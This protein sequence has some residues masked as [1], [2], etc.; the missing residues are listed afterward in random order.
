MP[1]YAWLTVVVVGWLLTAIT[2]AFIYSMVATRAKW[3]AYIRLLGE[4]VEAY[5]THPTST[6]QS[7]IAAAF[8]Q[9]SRE[10]T[11]AFTTRPIDN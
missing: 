7:D 1:W 8:E 3:K 10:M 11:Q 5:K 6:L 4:W 9:M 2:V